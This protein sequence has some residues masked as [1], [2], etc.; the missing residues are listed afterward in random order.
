MY[1]Q[2]DQKAASPMYGIMSSQFPKV[3][4][5]YYELQGTLECVVSFQDGD[6]SALPNVV[7][8]VV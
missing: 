3:A 5:H 1:N 6:V 4:A 2:N 7:L 8:Q